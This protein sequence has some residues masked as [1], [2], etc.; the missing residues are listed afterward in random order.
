MSYR[1]K[2]TEDKEIT[3]FFTLFFSFNRLTS[4]SARSL[5]SFLI[6]LLSK[7]KQ[8]GKLKKGE[9]SIPSVIFTP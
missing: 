1:G 3:G 4:S 9:L 5:F 8:E 6:I 7:S 2:K